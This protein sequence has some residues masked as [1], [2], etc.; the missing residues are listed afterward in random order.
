MTSQVVLRFPH[1]C[2]H[3]HTYAFTHMCKQTDTNK[4]K[5]KRMLKNNI[6]QS[7]VSSS[8][9]KIYRYISSN[10]KYWLTKIVEK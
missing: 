9:I 1:A 5:I 8:W 7:L 2:L 6:S 4:I 10:K 3:T